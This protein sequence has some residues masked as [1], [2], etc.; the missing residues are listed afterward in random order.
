L[1]ELRLP[2][3]SNP[4]TDDPT[5][6]RLVQE[7]LHREG[8]PVAIDRVDTLPEFAQRLATHSHALI[9]SDFTIPGMDTFEA[10]RLA[11][12]ARPDL[13]YVFFSG[14]LGED[15]AVE[16]LKRGATDYVL[17]DRPARLPSAVRR[18]LDE[19]EARSQQPRL[20]T[21]AFDGPAPAPLA[22]EA[23]TTPPAQRLWTRSPVFRYAAAVLAVGV[24][25]AV[26]A[27]L[28]PLLGGLQPFALF[29]APVLALGWWAGPGP[30]ALAAG[31]GWLI[32]DYFFCYPRYLLL[33]GAPAEEITASLVYLT[34]SAVLVP[35]TH[36]LRRGREQLRESQERFGLFMEH[37]PTLAWVKDEQGRYVFVKRAEAAAAELKS[38]LDAAL[39]AGEVGIFDWNLVTDRFWGDAS[40]ARFFDVTLDE[41]STVGLTDLMAVI[42]P[43]DRPIVNER[44][45]R[46]IE[47]GAPYEAEY[48]IITRDQTRWVVARATAQRDESGRAVRFPGVLVDITERKRAETLLRAAL[49]NIEL[50]RSRLSAVLEALPVGVAIADTEGKV[51]QFNAALNRLWGTPSV[52]RSIADYGHWRGRWAD[53]GQPL[54][55][56]DWAMARTL[57][58]GQVIPGEVVEID[59]FDG[60][61]TATIL[62]TAAP[63]R[64]LEG[65]IIGGV[66]AEV[67]LTERRRA[68]ALLRQRAEELA[69]TVQTRDE[70]LAQLNALL[71]NA[72]LGFAFFDREHR[73]ARINEFMARRING[74]SIPA[75][76]GRS[77]GE[78]LPVNARAID[79]LLDT[80]F[81]TGKSVGNVIVTGET[82]AAP[83]ERRHW[84]TAWF[85]VRTPDQQ[86]P[87]VGALFLDITDQQRTELALRHAREELARANADLDRAVRER[88]A[89]L[90]DTIADLEGFSYSLVHDLRAPLRAMQGYSALLEEETGPHLQEPERDLLRKIK[91]AAN[92]MDQLITDSLNYTRILRQ[93]LPLGPVH[94][95]E[96]LRGMV[97]TYP[98]LHPPHADISV[99]LGNLVVHGNQ[100]ALTQ[101]FSNLLGNAVKFV[102]PGVHPRVRVWAQPVREEPVKGRGPK[103]TPRAPPSTLHVP[104]VRVSVE[105]NGIGIPK[106][107]HERIFSMFQRLHHSDAYPGTGIGLALVK[108][109]L[110]RTGGRITLESGPGPGSRF[111]VELP[112]AA[113]EPPRTEG[114]SAP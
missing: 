64:D 20:G 99:E 95:D 101:V 62:N 70:A 100:A 51:L 45:Q 54:A 78:V 47:S 110:E 29:L 111:I 38:K 26:R 88:T 90:H 41:N 16:A 98:N 7:W 72:P 25:W 31:L 56:E 33:A 30:A 39:L 79:P 81:A 94:L 75:H 58:T 17:K 8:L 50:E 112:V 103:D 53:T 77:V 69:A 21:T 18:A 2:V 113:P 67:D 61:G 3:V 104:H 43:D 71:E 102:A 114:K 1:E 48:R 23:A 80:V 74:L 66:V 19:A 44:I 35:I 15:A 82:P 34:L 32:G 76:L 37:T 12:Q 93:E 60:S 14:T 4:D 89:K 84:L 108:K 59:K 91:V 109:S 105:D 57:R 6:S 42:H 106:H 40:F 27:A 24:T 87:W 5:T 96:L 73:Y 11:H 107:A 68:E 97:E 55:A 83:G 10:L 86:I 92:R 63:I 28:D 9:L 46:T 13:P 52:A 36:H 85:P 49:R 65:R 22:P